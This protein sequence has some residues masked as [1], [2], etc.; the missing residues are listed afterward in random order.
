[1]PKTYLWQSNG[2][3]TMVLSSVQKDMILEIKE[4]NLA[5]HR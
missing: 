3:R 2:M 1:M 5:F 4:T